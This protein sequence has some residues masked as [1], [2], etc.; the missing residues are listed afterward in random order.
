MFV[1]LIS[2][3]KKYLQV[4]LNEQVVARE[5]EDFDNNLWEGEKWQVQL[6]TL[7]HGINNVNGWY[8]LNTRGHC[9]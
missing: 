3:K 5:D 7:A 6:F 2:V 4:Q 8:T 9:K 1:N